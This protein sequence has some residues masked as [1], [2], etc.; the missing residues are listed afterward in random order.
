MIRTD[1]MEREDQRR[2]DRLQA[3][4][5]KQGLSSSD[6]SEVTEWVDKQSVVAIQVY[7]GGYLVYDSNYPEEEF[8][9]EAPDR[10]HP[11]EN[12]HT[13]VFSDG[14]ADV[15]LYG[16]YD[17]QFYNYAFIGELLLSFLLLMGI[18]MLGIRKTI[19][20][21]LKLS[22]EIRILEGGDLDY[23]I[24]ISGHDELSRLAEGL[25]SGDGRV[26]VQHVRVSG[27][28]VAERRK[29]VWL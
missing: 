3:Y 22:Q 23:L 11:W 7:K 24:T 5:T 17:Y 1:Y 25:A 16:F 6:A 20:Y 18:I 28:C 10:R 9:E 13:V 8:E 15:L 27:T 19:W 12:F 14:K 2:I 21:I 4:V 29:R 26:S